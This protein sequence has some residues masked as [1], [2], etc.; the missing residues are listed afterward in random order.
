MKKAGRG[1]FGWMWLA[2]VWLAAG[3]V[4][5]EDAGA[6]DALVAA[7]R[8]M[9]PDYVE[10]ARQAM[11]D[12]VG[13]VAG[14]ESALAERPAPEKRSQLLHIRGVVEGRAHLF[15]EALSSLR[16][17]LA[18]ATG[19]AG[20]GREGHVLNS[21]AGVFRSMEDLE[22]ASEVME[23]AVE[24]FEEGG[25]SGR[26]R[27]A[28][29][30]L[31]LLYQERGMGER[32][33]AQLEQAM[34]LAAAD[35]FQRLHTQHNLG[36]YY[37]ETGDGERALTFFRRAL[38]DSEELGLMDKVAL[39]HLGIARGYVLLNDVER[40]LAHGR[41]ALGFAREGMSVAVEIAA[42][43]EL[44]HCLE[45]LGRW[46]EAYRMQ[47]R[48]VERR[49]RQQ[50]VAFSP[51][52]LEERVALLAGLGIGGE[53]G[54]KRSGMVGWLAG[55]G[56]ALVLGIG[57]GW[58]V[59][60]WRWRRERREMRRLRH[61]M[62]NQLS[63]IVGI[64]SLLRESGLEGQSSRY[65]ATLEEAGEQLV[66]LMDAWAKAEGQGRRWRKSSTAEASEEVVGARERE[67]EEE[68]LRVVVLQEDSLQRNSLEAFLESRGLPVER[69]GDGLE[70][71][72]RWSESPPLRGRLL[73]VLDA[74]VA[75]GQQPLLRRLAIRWPRYRLGYL[76]LGGRG[77]T[78]NLATL[79]EAAA[80]LVLDW[81]VRRERLAE[82]V[83]RMLRMIGEEEPAGNAVKR[84][85][86]QVEE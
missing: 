43:E 16:E 67:P 73:V 77:E 5:A 31:G 19:H 37:L 33:K 42:L 32:A 28:Y 64:G 24:K 83:E 40:A 65:V 38:R 9:A 78:G 54:G 2:G 8:R 74:E 3:L 26:L 57:I 35:P 58:G 22:T 47:G 46:E 66:G 6:E 72:R 29:N 11:V 68:S 39:Q 85:G 13:A 10:L 4:L 69:N 49:K 36:N 55:M 71:V 75:R 48:Y 86:E 23:L 76:L 84:D 1:W 56:A 41:A 61:D 14:V 53:V 51:A 12:P 44:A 70:Q 81:P 52:S 34:A 30:N 80:R 15:E 59:T 50:R 27:M 17:A 62:R 20:A 7:A 79:P 63:G 21:I 45:L 25:D 82:S 60:E 18:L